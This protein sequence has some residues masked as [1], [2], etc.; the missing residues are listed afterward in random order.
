MVTNYFDFWSF[1][2]LPL[3]RCVQSIQYT[4]QATGTRG[5]GPSS[6][7]KTQ[8][9]RCSSLLVFVRV[10]VLVGRCSSLLLLM[11]VCVCVCWWVGVIVCLCKN[12]TLSF[13]N[14][15]M[16]NRSLLIMITYMMIVMVPL[17]SCLD[18]TYYFFLKGVMWCKIPKI[19]SSSWANNFLDL[20]KRTNKNTKHEN[21]CQSFY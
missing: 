19:G 18:F 2:S 20:R 14:D 3:L 11:R 13:L 21:T 4:K 5:T 17:I 9:G 8:V 12:V 10:C 7:I 15:T 6:T 16:L 1:V